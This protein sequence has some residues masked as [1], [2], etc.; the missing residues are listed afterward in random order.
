MLQLAPLEIVQP[1][2]RTPGRLFETAEEKTTGYQLK[3]SR[4]QRFDS[5]SEEVREK[6]D[7]A[8]W[9]GVTDLYTRLEYVAFVGDKNLV[10][11]VDAASGRL[12]AVY[13]G[14]LEA[15][16]P[17]GRGALRF[18]LSEF[19]E[20]DWSHGLPCGEGTLETKDYKYRGKFADGLP[21]GQGV[22]SLHRRFTYEGCF[23]QGKFRG[24]GKLIWALESKTYF[25]GFKDNLFEGRGLMLWSDGRKY[26]GDYRRGLKHGKGCCIFS[27]GKKIYVRYEDG[28]LL[29]QLRD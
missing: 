20:G 28:R 14:Q 17:H 6:K 3:A 1:H 15:G 26:F 12:I 23:S 21:E 16:L 2:L 5:F 27:S 4:P 8:R 9:D 29:E 25:G 19:Y 10:A 11:R 18:S 7:S 24:T 13:Q 22:L